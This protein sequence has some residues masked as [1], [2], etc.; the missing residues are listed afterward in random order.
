[1]HDSE[2]RQKYT[3]YYTVDSL[4]L[5]IIFPINIMALP[6][7]PQ[8]SYLGAY[9]V[10][11]CL[12]CQVAIRPGNGCETH[13]RR[14]HQLQGQLLKDLLRYTSTLNFNDPHHMDL[15]TRGSQVI[16]E[17]GIPVDGFNCP[18][19]EFLTVNKKKWQS[20]LRQHQ[21]GGL[22][23]AAQHRVKMQTFSRGR[24]A[25][26]W[27]V[28]DEQGEGTEAEYDGGLVNTND[29]FQ[30]MLRTYKDKYNTQWE[31]RRQIAD[32]PKGVENQSRWVQ[33]MGWSTL[34]NGKDKRMIY[35]AGLMPRRAGIRTPAHRENDASLGEVDPLL[36]RLGESFDRV[37]QRC[38]ARL[39]LVPHESL[40]WLN[41]IDPMKP[42]GRPFELKQNEKS[43]YR[44][45]QFVKRC[46]VYSV[47]AGRLG[48]EASRQSHGIRWTDR[49]WEWLQR[50]EAA[51]GQLGEASEDNED[52]DEDEEDPER[53]RALDEVV[54]AYCI[55]MLQQQVLVNWYENP[56]LFFAAVLGINDARGSWSEPK[57]YTGSLAGL[58]W[59]GRMLL[60][61][62]AFRESPEDP[63]EMTME[64]VEGFQEVQRRWLA[65][66][67][68]SPMSTLIT[69]MAYG[70]GFRTKEGG[71]PKVLWEQ[72]GEVMR[73]LNQ[74][75]HV[76]DFMTMAQEAVNEAEGMLDQLIYDNWATV[77]STIDLGRIQDSVSYEGTGCS[78]ATEPR[79][80]WLRAGFHFVAERA[81]TTMWPSQGESKPRVAEVKAWIRRFKAFK[82]LLMVMMH[83]WGG[84]PGR[85]PEMT[86]LKHCDTPQLMRNVFVFDSG[87]LLIT[88]RD[89]NRSIRGLGRKVARF[90]PER[91]S[92]MVVAY[93]AWLMPF[94]E[95]IHDVSGVTGPDKSLWSYMWKDARRGAW[96]TAQLSD[97]LAALTGEHLGVE[98]M[99]SDYRHVAIGFARVI[100]GIVVRRME[101]EIEEGEGEEV[102][103][104]EETATSGPK[105]EW[106]WDA[107]STHG[108]V[109]AADHYA[110]D[111]RFPSRMQPEKLMKFQ[112][113]S[114]LWHR[115]LE[116]RRGEKESKVG[117]EH[118]KGT[119]TV[120]V[121]TSISS[122]ARHRKRS[123][124]C[125]EEGGE[126]AVTSSSLPRSKRVRHESAHRN[127][128]ED[129]PRGLERLVGRL[130]TWR[131]PEQGEA[132][133]KI[134]AMQGEESLTVVLPTGAGK[135]VLFMLPA[136]VEAWGTTVVIVPFAALM[137][138]LVTRACKSGIDCIRWRP[139]RLQGR[140][141]PMRVARLVVASAD[142]EE[143]EQFRDYMGSL[144]DRKLLR[145][146]FVDEAHTVIMDVS[147]RKKLD[148][149][150]GIYR[151]GCPVIALTATLPGVV[152]PWFETTML[153]TGSV[154]IRAC[155]V[156]RNIRYN[157][158]RVT[159][160]G[161]KASG[162]VRVEVEDEVVRVVLR[163]EKQMSG[164]QKGVVYVRSR[165]GCEALAVKLGCEYYHSGIVDESERR[166]TLQRWA[167]GDAANRWIVAT[168]GLGTGV[169]I[170]GIVAVV[171]MEQP[172][173]LVDFVQQTGRGGRQAGEVVESVVVMDQRKAWIGEHRS[174]VEHLNHQAMEWFVESTG[175][176]RVVVGMFM[177]VGLK[178]AGM[179]CEQLQAEL[180]DWC[181][182][183]HARQEDE[184]MRDAVEEENDRV[185]EVE[186]NEDSAG[187]GDEDNED[188]DE[189]ESESGSG[190]DLRSSDESPTLY[191][192]QFR[193]YVREKHTRFKEWRQWLTEASDHCPVCYVQWIRDGRTAAW[194]AKV[195]HGIRECPRVDF[196]KLR[197]WRK[198]L[199]FG[200][201]DCCWECGLPQSVCRGVQDREHGSQGWNELGCEWGDQVVPMLYW[202][203]GDATW[204]DKVRSVFGFN[205]MHADDNDWHKQQPYRRWLGRARRMYDE[206]MTNAIAVWDMVIQEV[207]RS[208]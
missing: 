43:M 147:Y 84:Q 208:M 179:D 96:E 40:L 92:R 32:D 146:I 180:C 57:H 11:I 148:Q 157:V 53:Q 102:E 118:K 35:Q 63:N 8:I 23:R 82:R 73:Y 141:L 91:V 121:T 139:G 189:S 197:I 129:I 115:F 25:R 65:G 127:V 202:I 173:G 107:Q 163:L 144:R 178:E 164:I 80:V 45:R 187:E 89:K 94:E 159:S 183:K 143:V 176:R 87:V 46:L 111:S 86:T 158:V 120:T 17:L 42:A 137:D 56:L 138:D 74:S 174:D 136:L 131:M 5:L 194:H 52:D 175:C 69:W 13:W 24:H 168:T 193:A 22:S 113:I 48:R 30:L 110:I 134:M 116:G 186:D 55:A 135:S 128:L 59:C 98:A 81:R 100:K 10:I 145:R 49:Q 99:V 112:E 150:K 78:F 67:S 207:S 34:F 104:P 27:I 201:Y 151:Y 62:E 185:E 38:A 165:E 51:L 204:R 29:L 170:P 195:T 184:A 33:F 154:M 103:G 169:D 50:I 117:K 3:Q 95:F 9:H 119:L 79:N 61:E 28:C 7:P 149:I 76:D 205:S 58:V 181:R 1:M 71:T 88:D 15:P 77:A 93:I 167:S 171:H 72:N 172:Y 47:R 199:N 177:D 166:A 108:S 41:S 188:E 101:V 60:L 206:D 19:C 132:M 162:G 126:G 83:I 123:R 203:K 156:K 125:M 36:M 6:V 12:E 140:E 21:H 200:E 161:K 66:G 70:K 18:D 133:E 97:G 26:Y 37:M 2:S 105:W 124:T 182:V 54:F 130:A 106:I 39:K 191:P 155:T 198:G 68:Y 142:M 20:H 122:S 31:E 192:N 4:T 152:V 196:E 44:Y 160:G 109:I 90:L 14:R 85:G 190:S 64:M 75:I 114:Q 153:M 16:P